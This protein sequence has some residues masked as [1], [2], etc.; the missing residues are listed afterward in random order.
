MRKFSIAIDIDAPPETVWAVMIATDRWHEWTPSIRSARRLG[1]RPFGMGTRVLIR[2]P[3]LPPAVWTIISLDEGRSFAWTSVGPGF[4]V[5]ARHAVE[6]ET[7]GSRA[8]LSLDFQGIFGGLF[9]RLT[10]DINERYLA[11]E[12]KGLKAR[13]ESFVAG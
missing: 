4:R 5:F 2:Q 8:T 12:A 3:R 9:G 7:R 1:D 11:L 13:S 10:R 6:R